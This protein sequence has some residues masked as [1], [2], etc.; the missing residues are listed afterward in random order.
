MTFVGKI[1]VIV[2]TAFALFFAA[3]SVVV[4]TA[5][6]NWQEALKA[7]K[8]NNQK[9]SQDVA[10]A[11]AELTKREEALKAEL[12]RRDNELKALAEQ[13]KATQD[14]L[15]SIQTENTKLR[16]DNE[17]AQQTS[18]SAIEEA[19]ALAA[20]TATIRERFQAAQKQANDLKAR[21]TELTQQL[22]DLERKFDTATQQ[23][24][25]LRE[26]MT[27]YR[28]FLN[29]RGLPSDPAQLRLAESGNA[30]PP[31]VEGQVLAVNTKNDLIE[32]SI[33]S[34]DG[35][36]VGQ[37]YYVFRTASATPEFIGKI[38]ITSA[39][40]DQAVGRVIQRYLGRKV[41]EGDHVAGQI[42][43]RS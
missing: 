2:I 24:K 8:D 17:V 1:L 32:I 6:T 37:E 21:Q 36:I 10:D 28:N 18:K 38:K 26:G 39:E 31:D 19:Q 41:A 43:P 9:L 35:V 7:Q 13:Q 5:T 3:L 16:T 42:Q 30:A 40:A 33:G 25:D 22:Y 34:D 14:E 23:N 11:K 4:F 29:S 15:A 12:A 20:E 27:T